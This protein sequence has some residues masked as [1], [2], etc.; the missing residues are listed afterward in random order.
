MIHFIIDQLAAA[1]AALV[2]SLGAVPADAPVVPDG[3]PQGNGM[4][5]E[6]TEVAM[7]DGRI[8]SCLSWRHGTSGGLSCDWAGAR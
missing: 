7:P 4:E 1:I 6:A 2:L 5:W 3:V 8:V